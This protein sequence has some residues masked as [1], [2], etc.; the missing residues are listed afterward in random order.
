MAVVIAL[1]P[2]HLIPAVMVVFSPR[3]G[4]SSAGFV[5]GWVGGLLLVTSIG[6]ALAL[7]LDGVGALADGGQDWQSTAKVI[8]GALLT[9]A[10]L[11]RWITRASHGDPPRWV[12]SL[13]AVTPRGAVK[14]GLLLSLVNPKVLLVAGAAGAAIG[15]AAVVGEVAAG[16][17]GNG[18]V[19]LF[20]TLASVT[21]VLPML[22]YLV[23]GERFKVPLAVVRDQ[24][25]GNHAVA[26]A[27]MIGG[28]GVVVLAEGLLGL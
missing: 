15:S 11:R 2:V 18:A 21:V 14:L 28:L 20:V 24:L 9:L 17:L 16:G 27:V 26:M 3:A 19:A 6:V 1:S 4:A 25:L 7:G 8:V 23:W 22:G 13:G 5:A 10:G 12:G